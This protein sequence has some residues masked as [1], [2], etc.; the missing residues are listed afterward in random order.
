MEPPA[1]EASPWERRRSDMAMRIERC[2]LELCVAQG[3]DKTTMEDIAKAAGISRRT[4]YRYFGTID[5]ILIAQSKRSL[6]RISR[7]VAE[8]PLSESVREAFVN[9]S[10]DHPPSDDER[11]ILELGGQLCESQPA[12]WWRAMGRVQAMTR[13]VYEG[14]VAERLAAAGQDPKFAPM[15]AAVLIAVI[16]FTAQQ[17]YADNGKFSPSAARL[18]E[19]LAALSAIMR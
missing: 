8:R 16:G 12:P 10:R 19:A 7:S 5:E 6:T 15:I 18:E 11:Y 14:A 4:V 13:E 17:S 9:A 3:I 1:V 2:A